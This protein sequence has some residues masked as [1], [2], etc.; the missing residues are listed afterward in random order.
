MIITDEALANALAEMQKQGF[1]LGKVY[2]NPYATAFKPQI[3]DESPINKKFR[4]YEEL[5]NKNT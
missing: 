2:S 1:E 3:N 5:C 4:E